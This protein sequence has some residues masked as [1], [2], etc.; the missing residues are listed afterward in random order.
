MDELWAAHTEQLARDHRET[1]DTLPVWGQPTP[2]R[3]RRTT[4]TWKDRI[5]AQ[6]IFSE[7]T[8][9]ASPYRR[10]KLVMD[11]WCALWF[12]P[13]EAA[14]RLP[15]REAFLNE[16]A[17]VLTGSV[18][19]PDLGPNQT[20][21]LFGEEYAEHAADIARRISNE[22]GMLDLDRLFEQFP[23]LKFVDELARRHRFHHWELAFADLFYG[24][25]SDGRM[26][27]GFDLVL[28]NPPWV[29][30]E[31]EEAGVLGDYNP[32]VVLRGHSAVEISALRSNAFERHGELRSAWFTELEEAEATQTYLN[33]RQNFPL[34]A[35]QKTNLYKCFVPQ[36][37]MVAS[38]AGVAGFLHPESLYDDPKGGAFREAL[39]PRLRAHFQFQNEKRLFEVGHPALFSIN[40][41]GGTA[42]DPAFLHI[43]N[44]F[45]PA[46]VDACLDHNGRGP[47]PGIK[48]DANDWNTAG[49]F[50]RVVEVDADALASFATLY[51]V[52][53]T[54]PLM[55]RLPALH[56]KPL[57]AVL[58]K[59]AAPSETSRRPEGRVPRHRPLERDHG[60]TRR[61]H[62]QG[63]AVPG[64]SSGARP[65]RS[66]LLRRKSLQQDPA[67]GM[68]AERPLRHPGS[69]DLARRL[70]AAH[71]LRG[72]MQPGRV[73]TAH[74]KG[75][76]AGG[77]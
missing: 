10:L 47:V 41:Y 15:D 25:G 22:I 69:H 42:P 46:T 65:V 44:L 5:R 26:H 24:V 3:E 35:G 20:A 2:A 56:A 27:G 59:L 55:A 12:W 4:N 31:W 36:A 45:A 30:V 9:T 61:N 7:G 19:Q 63:D 74:A 18:Y 72:R 17:L 1:E 49:H 52:P 70:P 71:E 11:Y 66:P 68:Y 50:H 29:K 39:Y 14:D 77:G 16:I 48:D 58:R 76:V 67:A 75:V 53:G 34:L 51:D 33:A 54:P 57:L 8:R 40:V 62:P 6:G 13:I 64:A 73:R 43:A 60:A 38:E 32:L 21:D 28:G 23:R 37:W